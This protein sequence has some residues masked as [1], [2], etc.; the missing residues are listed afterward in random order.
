MVLRKEK[1][2]PPFYLEKGNSFTLPPSSSFISIHVVADD[3]AVDTTA[4]DAAS[5]MSAISFAKAV[6]I[7]AKIIRNVVE[8]VDQLPIGTNVVPSLKVAA[9]YPIVAPSSPSTVHV[10]AQKRISAVIGDDVATA[11]SRT[12]DA[13]F[14]SPSLLPTSIPITIS[15]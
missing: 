9:S 10:A 8:T 5:L 7:I 3:V 6:K 4:D 14:V 12:V 1:K 13:V 2:K 15:S 11:V